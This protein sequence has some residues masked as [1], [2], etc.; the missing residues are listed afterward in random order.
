MKLDSQTIAEAAQRVGIKAEELAAVLQ[1]GTAVSYK[2]GDY[3]FHESTPRQWLGLVI[4]G[5]IDLVRGQ[6]G[7]SVL[8]GVAQP[9]AILSESVMLDGTPHATSARTHQGTTVWQIPRAELETVRA[10]H[11]EI[12]YRIVGQIAQR[13]S[14]RLRLALDFEVFVVFLPKGQPLA[15]KALG[16]VAKVREGKAGAAAQR[17][18]A[19]ELRE[20]LRRWA[21]SD[22]AVAARPENAPTQAGVTLRGV[23][24]LWR[25]H[26]RKTNF[27]GEKPGVIIYRHDGP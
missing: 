26:A 7:N 8:M 19:R 22:S 16:L 13:L 21:A 1:R 20:E 17:L 25:D 9:G 2:A 5:E 27:S 14:E 11:P 10:E 3:L 24:F 18:Q 12:F 15:E 4:E 6:H 23:R